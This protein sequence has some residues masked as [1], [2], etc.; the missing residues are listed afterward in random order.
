VTVLTDAFSA[1]LDLLAKASETIITSATG[2]PGKSY[3]ALVVRLHGIPGVPGT[4]TVDIVASS[5]A[6]TPSDSSLPVASINAPFIDESTPVDIAASSIAPPPSNSPPTSSQCQPCREDPKL[7][8]I[9]VEHGMNLGRNRKFHCVY[10]KLGMNLGCK[11]DDTYQNVVVAH[12][13]NCGFA[14]SDRTELFAK[15]GLV[16]K[17]LKCKYAD[18]RWVFNDQTEDLRTKQTEARQHFALL[19]VQ[20]HYRKHHDQWEHPVQGKDFYACGYCKDYNRPKTNKDALSIVRVHMAVC[21]YDDVHDVLAR[22]AQ[23]GGLGVCDEPECTWVCK[24]LWDKS[25][26]VKTSVMKHKNTCH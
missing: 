24:K 6:P 9:R 10:G 22:R 25:R 19:K 13:K 8:P 18:C 26:Y 5:I 2:T 14:P 21:G 12:I 3:D 1:I 16:L 20:I 17:D 23:H 11:Y 15:H 7:N 4:N